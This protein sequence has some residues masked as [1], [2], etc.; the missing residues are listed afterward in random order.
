[1]AHR[2]GLG[3]LRDVGVALAAQRRLLVLE[4]VAGGA[5]AVRV[6]AGEALALRR[7]GV[8]VFPFGVGTERMEAAAAETEP[9]DRMLKKAASRN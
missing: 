8:R 3:G 1:V 7:R 9:A 4:Q 5:S 2:L 6:V